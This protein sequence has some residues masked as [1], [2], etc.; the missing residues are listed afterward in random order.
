MNTYCAVYRL[1]PERIE[2]Y[3]AL[4]ANCWPEQL[5]ALRESGAENLEIFLE[6]ALCIITYEC[7]DFDRFLETLS[8]SEVNRRWQEAMRGIF[9]SNTN[10]TGENKITPARKVFSLKGQLS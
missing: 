5:H 7:A 9:E 4:H 6:G 2:E 8:G 1:K 3:C 10:L